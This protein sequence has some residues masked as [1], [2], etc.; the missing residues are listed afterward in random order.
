[1]KRVRQTIAAL[2]CMVMLFTMNE[3]SALAAEMPVE[4]WKNGIQSETVE[5]STEQ[6]G[7]EDAVKEVTDE[8]QKEAVDEVQKEDADDAVKEATDEVQK[9]AVDKVQE[10]PEE[11]TQK[12][13]IRMSYLAFGSSYVTT[14]GKQYVIVGLDTGSTL[15]TQAVIHYENCSTGER[16]QT[17]AESVEPDSL[18]F[19][20]NFPDTGYTGSYRVIAVDYETEGISGT[21][22]IADTGIEAAFGVN[23]E[24]DTMPD[25]IAVDEAALEDTIGTVITDAEGKVLS[26][27]DLGAAI[28]NANGLLEE[29][30]QVSATKAG[31]LVVVLDPG[32][33][34]NDPGAMRTVNG[35]TY[36]ESQ[37]N[38]KIAQY[39]KKELET[40]QGVS[41]YMTR[42]T[43]ETMGSSQTASLDARVAKAVKYK[44]DVLISF[45]LN[46]NNNTAVRGAVVYYPN[47]NY[48][49]EVGTTG[50]ELAEKIQAQLVELGILDRGAQFL[51]CQ[52][53]KYPDGSLADYYGLIRRAK[54]SGIPCVLIEHLFM[55]NEAE[56]NQF[57]SSEEKLQRLGIA[58]ATGIAEYYGLKKG[59][60]L[61]IPLFT[62]LKPNGSDE[63]ELEWLP[64]SGA[65]SYQ[66]YRSKT[67][68]GGYEKIYETEDGEEISYADSDCKPGVTYYY[69]IRACSD[70]VKS[71][72]SDVLSA[73]TLKQGEITSTKSDGT[74]RL[75]IKWEKV[76]NAIGYQLYRSES[77]GGKYKK[78]ADLDSATFQYTDENINKGVTYY[79]K[80]RAY[81]SQNGMTVYGS[82]SE[83]A[84]GWSISATKIT[85][86]AAQSDG[87]FL[88]EWKK[89]KNAYRYQ[90]YRSTTADGT[91]KRIA[92][93]KD[94]Y[95]ED[96]DVKPKQTY[97]YKIRTVNNVAGVKGYGDYSASGYSIQVSKTSITSMQV[98]SDT[99]IKI[100]W[101]QT[102]D[103][104]GYNLYRATKKNGDYDLVKSIEKG[105]TTSYTDKRLK[106]GKT[107]YYK[108]QVVSNAGGYEGEGPLSAYK[109]GQTVAK[110]KISYIK[111]ISS[112]KLKLEWQAVAGADG[113]RIARSTGKDGK[114]TVIGEVASGT[115]VTYTDKTVKAGKKYYYKVSAIKKLRGVVG[116]SGY[117]EALGGK[118]VKPAEFAAP[119]SVAQA[120][121]HLEWLKVKGAAGYELYRSEEAEGGY[122]KIATIESGNILSYK[123]VPPKTNKTYYYKIR[124]FNKNQ[125][126]VGYSEYSAVATGKS[127][128]VPVLKD[129]TQNA[130]AS[131]NISWNRVKGAKKYR[132]YRKDG[133]SATFKKLAEVKSTI[134]EYQDETALAGIRYEYKVIAY[135]SVNGVT[136]SSGY[137]AVKSYM[138]EMYEIMGEADVTEEQMVSYYNSMLKGM[139]AAEPLKNYAY[140]AELYKNKGAAD[141]ETF[142]SILYEEATEE[143]VRPEV[144]FSQLCNETYFL[145]FGG[146]VSA[147]QCNFAGIGA[148]GGGEEG[149]TFADVRTGLRAQV[150]HLKAYACG[151]KL[152]QECVD[153]RFEYV[154]RGTC[155]YVEWLGIQENP[156]TVF[157]A[158]GTILSG[159]GWATA[160]NY[161]YI[162]RNGII[163]MKKF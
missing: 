7:T 126:V 149:N 40:Y 91:Y 152:E 4:E 110:T 116:E 46:T 72:F 63:I 128:A 68:N 154:K 121:I 153:P 127:L 70:E 34:G 85:S 26:E 160:K 51:N 56:L 163:R 53:D 94:T 136:G 67:E 89:I 13:E 59:K 159:C 103:A 66:I 123:D 95:Y 64:V 21:I 50:H 52:D 138:I 99:R 39:C 131:L 27:S 33:G 98:M 102:E 82:R 43:D 14:P 73:Y 113:Y 150:Q 44:A 96:D 42:T 139:Q 28:S 30:A 148:T 65:E 87:T 143:G 100:S 71:K 101:K 142:V 132:I 157:A 117:S 81:G 130:D 6:T 35:V 106:P 54:L 86:V 97:Y 55:S 37:L 41:V 17:V 78:I 156:N 162:L 125:K 114:Y 12:Q 60:N 105:S 49:A 62:V 118:S 107:Y 11:E 2:L 3:V 58:D 75:I 144:V 76:K 84:E 104:A 108:I 80:I 23:Q 61:S 19:A 32:H 145:Q 47:K 147:G 112:K 29:S 16:Y 141:I 111:S 31:G 1:M 10:E 45:H 25:A 109:K 161:G 155:K 90:V 9:E 8:A 115:K 38:L 122:L 77:E 135:N 83:A 57:L 134:Y 140:P 74:K 48:N 146:D 92:T 119:K 120:A 69:K 24:P 5:L 79:Y 137:S 93:V 36:K 15:V 88:V 133:T 158:D 124:T 22:Q 20:L 129:I 151:D 18:I